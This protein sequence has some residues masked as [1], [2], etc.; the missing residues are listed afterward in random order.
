MGVMPLLR[1][2]PL[3]FFN[4]AAH[5]HG[6]VVS[7]R[8]GPM[9]AALVRH[10][11]AVKHVLVDNNHNYDKQTRAYDVLRTF[12][13]S[14]LLTSEGDFWRRQRR[15]AQPA[16]HRRK[17]AA[18]GEIMV[19]QTGEMLARWDDIAGQGNTVDVAAEMASLT[20][21]IVGQTL[22]STEVDTNAG[23]IGEAVT[24]LNH[25][26]DRAIDSLLPIGFPTLGTLRAWEASRRLDAVID[27][28]IRRRRDG[29]QRDDLLGMLMET[30]DAD[31][32]ETMT[33]RQLRDEVM[34]IFLAGHET[35]ATSLAWTFYLLSRHPDVERRLR[36]ELDRELAGRQPSADDLPRLGYLQQ[37]VKESMRLYPP[38]WIIDRRC[39]ADDV[40]MGYQIKKHTLVL[41]SPY[42]THRHPELWPNPEGF[43]PDRFVA[44]LEES[45]PRYAYFPFGGGP[46][47][48]IGNGFAMMEAQ[49]IV[50]TVLQRFR[51]WLVPGHPVEQEPLVTL[52]PRFGLQMGL[53]QIATAA[54]AA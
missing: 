52:R 43:D 26:A 40:V 37:V 33:N 30:R 36:A 7:F 20:L 14:G 32:G 39:V 12:L 17:I 19:H 22:L 21:R 10:P 13:G 25:W 3:R 35:T 42:L 54:E 51:P 27:A 18:F 41:L 5:R 23:E 15:I 48:C 38:A 24:R 50:A 4:D 31:T 9:Q 16:F 28:I 44:T 34:T 53:A 2:D 29:E 1:S 11:E 46:R 49:L 8:V 45:R 47:Q 6:D